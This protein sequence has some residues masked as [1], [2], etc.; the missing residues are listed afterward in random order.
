MTVEFVPTEWFDE[1][2]IKLPNYK[3]GR[4]NFGLGRSYIKIDKDGTL[5]Q[6]FKLYT[7]LTTSIAQS[8]PTP[9]AL[10]DWKFSLGKKEADRQM[11]V[12][13]HF[14]TMMHIEIGKFIME[15]IYDLDK[16]D[17]VVENYTSDNNFWDNDCAFWADELKEDLLAFVQFYND[18]EI[19]PLGLEYVLLSDERGFGTPIDLVCL[20]TVDE[21]GE[22]GEVYKSGDRKGD[23]KI[24]TKRVQKRAIIN[25][26]SGRKGFYET[27]GIQ[28]ECE[29]LLWDENFPES[30]IDIAMNWAPADWKTTPSY[31]IKEWQG[32]TSQDEIDAILKLAQIRYQDKAEKRQ[33]MSMSGVISTSESVAGAVQFEDVE[34]FCNRKFGNTPNKKRT[35]KATEAKQAVLT[36]TFVSSSLPI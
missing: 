36:K 7:S 27:H 26:K 8:M 30:P 12:R 17:E 21:K 16:C 28:M 6:P 3:V 2:A 5:A 11:K 35:H 14:G 32:T 24:T 9:K 1:N 13:A 10:E 25:F 18:Y 33:Y 19:I 29:K 15:G 23:P 34:D 31:K 20:L 4:V 22:W